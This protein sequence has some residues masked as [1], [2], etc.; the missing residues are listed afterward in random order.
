MTGIERKA[1]YNRKT[2]RKISKV[3]I[4]YLNKIESAQKEGKI[5]MSSHSIQQKRILQ[6]KDRE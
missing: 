4:K 2:I 6:T 5:H 1:G 3:S